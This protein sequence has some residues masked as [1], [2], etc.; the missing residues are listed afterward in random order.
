MDGVAQ[1][2]LTNNI[3]GVGVTVGG[4]S[5]RIE[6]YI[7]VGVGALNAKAIVSDCCAL[8]SFFV[9]TVAK[10]GASCT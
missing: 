3:E 5:E 10:F 4:G 1:G 9:D 6:R 7:K 2:D 8:V